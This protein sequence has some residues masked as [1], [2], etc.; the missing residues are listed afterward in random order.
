MENM[1]LVLDE[2]GAKGYATTKEKY[3]GEVGVMA[4]FMDTESEINQIELIFD[5]I[6]R[7][8]CKNI[9]GKFHITDLKNEYQ[10]KFREDIFD[11]I[12][13]TRLQWF[14]KAIYAE[15][16]HQS[17]FLEGRGGQKNRKESLHAVLFQKMLIMS[18]CMAESIGKNN[19]HLTIK[20]DNVDDGTLKKFE[21]ECEYVSGI[22]LGREREIFTRVKDEETGK[23]RKEKAMISIVSD[24][25]PKFEDISFEIVRESSPLTIAADVLANSVNFYLRGNQESNVGVFLNNKDIIKHHPLADLAFIPKSEEHVTPLLD[26]VYRRSK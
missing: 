3:E 17:E 25:I 19:V 4:G 9:D 11:A 22:F 16:F 26:I 14:F 23:Y 8:Y 20:T 5:R 10:E 2:S 21:K 1:V 18:I 24:S 12:R 15:G 6:I 7:K 13:R